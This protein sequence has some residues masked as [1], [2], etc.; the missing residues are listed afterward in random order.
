[1][2]CSEDFFKIYKKGYLLFSFVPFFVQKVKT[3]RTNMVAYVVWSMR[4]RVN[5]KSEVRSDL[6]YITCLYI[7][8][9]RGNIHFRFSFSPSYMSTESSNNEYLQKS[10]ENEIP[11]FPH[12]WNIMSCNF[13]SKQVGHGRR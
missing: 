6:A 7:S 10:P 4:V 8:L 5:F 12:V 1:M 2:K 11:Y 9:N 13:E 3:A